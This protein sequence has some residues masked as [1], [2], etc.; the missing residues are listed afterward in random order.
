[1]LL[2]KCDRELW[3]LIAQFSFVTTFLIRKQKENL[4]FWGSKSVLFLP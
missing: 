4:S 3:I 1:M 2:L